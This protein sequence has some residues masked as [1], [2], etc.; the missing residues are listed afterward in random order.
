M[1]HT[2][3]PPKRSSRAHPRVRRDHARAVQLRAGPEARQN[4]VPT[5]ASAPRLRISITR[6]GSHTRWVAV[7]QAGE[8]VV[9]SKLHAGPKGAKQGLIDFVLAVQADDFETFDLT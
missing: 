5:G 6:I 7:N 8:T 2:V 9:T 1:P 4:P 3:K